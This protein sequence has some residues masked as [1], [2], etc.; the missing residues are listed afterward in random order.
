MN[1]R[2]EFLTDGGDTVRELPLYVCPES[3][4]WLDWFHVTMRLTVMGQM[5]KGLALEQVP[6]AQVGD[7]EE[8][9]RL[10]VPA[11]QKQGYRPD[12]CENML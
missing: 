12:W 6:L 10:D 1:Q 9:V 8:L 3:E 11:L 2:V 4:H 7:E 5:A